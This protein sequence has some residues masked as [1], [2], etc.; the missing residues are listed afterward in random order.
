MGTHPIF[1]SDFDCLTDVCTYTMG[2][3][4]SFFRRPE[5]DTT[6][7]LSSI[8]TKLKSWN[9]T[10]SLNQ[11]RLDKLTKNTLFYGILL[12]LLLIGCVYVL[13]PPEIIKRVILLVFLF[14]IYPVAVLLIRKFLKYCFTRK[15]DEAV[16]SV[17][18]L[19]KEKEE[20]LENVMEKEPYNKAREIL[21]KF[22]P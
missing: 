10:A 2:T 5:M 18:R 6:A 7:Q 15:K 20:I 12:G 11:S 3:M 13:F 17:S 9:E 22:A 19:K 1:E 4:I 8:E 16:K 21:K 14:A